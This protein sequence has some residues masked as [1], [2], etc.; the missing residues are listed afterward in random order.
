[1]K[2]QIL[3][4]VLY[5]LLVN[6]IYAS[7][8]VIER[9]AFDQLANIHKNEQNFIYDI[10]RTGGCWFVKYKMT[11]EILD[12]A[13]RKWTTVVTDGSLYATQAVRL[14]NVNTQEVIMDA[15]DMF[16]L[17]KDYKTITRMKSP[18]HALEHNTYLELMRDSALKTYNVSVISRVVEDKDTIVC[19]ELKPINATTSIHN[20]LR[21][22]VSKRTQSFI[23]VYVEYNTS[24]K[25]DIRHYTLNVTSR[26]RM[27]PDKNWKD[28][29]SIFLTGNG[30]LKK[31][32]QDYTFKDLTI[33]SSR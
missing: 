28:I 12:P 31:D 19:Y 18:E 32:Y 3:I 1:M 5:G 17:N 21:F 27:A 33:I 2:K 25:R 7:P 4:T 20:R 22:F 16:V 8:P 24:V 13:S 10:L 26:G 15:K 29:R 11:S 30:Q 14:V 9:P 6:T 23:R